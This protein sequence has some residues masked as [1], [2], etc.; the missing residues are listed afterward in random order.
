MSLGGGFLYMDWK[1]GSVGKTSMKYPYI[2][3]IANMCMTVVSR[4]IHRKTEL[5]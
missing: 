4:K 3:T 2:H 5:S 1:S